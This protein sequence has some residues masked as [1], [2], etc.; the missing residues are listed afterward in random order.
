MHSQIQTFKSL[1]VI[2][3]I[4]PPPL[5]LRSRKF[6]VSPGYRPPL[7]GQPSNSLFP[8]RVSNC[9]STASD[10]NNVNGANSSSRSPLITDEQQKDSNKRVRAYPFNKIE[11]KWQQYWEQ[12][13]TFRTPD[14]DIDTSKPKYYV[15]DMFPYPRSY[16]ILSRMLFYVIAYVMCKKVK[17]LKMQLCANSYL[18]YVEK[19]LVCFLFEFPNTPFRFLLSVPGF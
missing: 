11:P 4:A 14:D 1:P 16:F 13:K 6:F 3:Q 18:S 15:L 10:K 8:L 9:V 19:F 7:H 5:R 12:H 2:P 17:T